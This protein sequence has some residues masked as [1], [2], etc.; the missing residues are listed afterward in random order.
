MKLKSI[1]P[2][3][4]SIITEFEEFSDQ[5]VSNCIIDCDN[6]FNVWKNF[7]IGERAKLLAKTAGILINNREDFARTI[8]AEMGKPIKESRAEIEKCAWV[9]NFYSENAAGMLKPEIIQTEAMLSRV[10][11]EPLG[12]ILGIMPWNFPFWQV[13]RFAAPTLTAG[14]SVIL[15]H[16]SNVQ[17]CANH[18]EH[19]FKL[20]GYPENVFRNLPIKSARIAELISHNAIKAITLTGSVP[21]GS[22]VAAEAGKN[23]KKTVLELGGNNAFVV[24]EDADIEKAVEIGIAARMQN[25]GQSCI[26]AKRFFVHSKI[27]EKFVSLYKEKIRHLRVGDPMDENID[28]GPLSSISLAAEVEDQVDASIHKGAK[29]EFLTRRRQAFYYPAILTHVKPGMPVFDEEVFGPVA[30]VMEFSTDE[31]VVGLINNSVFGLGATL[32]TKNMQR[33]EKIIPQISDGA[34]FVNSMV[35]SDPRLPFGG[36]KNSGYGRELSYL[37]IREFTNIKTVFIDK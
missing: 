8:T 7:D 3:T 33:A 4:N 21:A 13:F 37:G 22:Q 2:Y 35:K 15:K 32:F 1:N 14:N 34:V 23:I 11:Y 17:G 29:S 28:I 30:A 18:I 16:A 9:C 10:Q 24:F 25:A 12:V 36:T 27:A 6:A 19:I 5:Q 31:E 20:A 26:A